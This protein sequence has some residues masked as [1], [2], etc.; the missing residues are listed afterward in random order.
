MDGSVLIVIVVAIVII[1]CLVKLQ[2]R[3][4]RF[5]RLMQKY[6][7][8]TVVER[9]MARSY[10]QGMTDEMLIDSLG[11]PVDIGTRVLKAKKVETYKYDRTGR[12]RYGT[13]IR[14]ENGFVVGWE[15]K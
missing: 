5:A 8:Q 10:W 13:R 15:R 6:N 11:A 12:N 1:V 14:V 9:I 4:A 3:R 2:A 7:D